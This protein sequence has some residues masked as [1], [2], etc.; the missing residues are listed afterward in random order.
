MNQRV[1]Q[2]KLAALGQ[3]SASIAH[4]IRNPLAAIAQANELLSDSELHEQQQLQN[5]IRKQTKR[6]NGI[7]EDTLGMARNQTTTPITIQLN[8]FLQ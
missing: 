3:L 2:L 7:I 8:P 4:E 1:Q 5:M 6:I